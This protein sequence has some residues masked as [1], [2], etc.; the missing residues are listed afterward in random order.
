LRK[1]QHLHQYLTQAPTRLRKHQ[2]LHQY[3][4]QYLTQSPTRLRKHQ[5]LTQAPT[6][7]LTEEVLDILTLFGENG[8]LKPEK[9]A[10]NFF[11]DILKQ[12]LFHG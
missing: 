3:L 9:T 11:V 7:S 12:P 10:P 8:N 4:T 1:H 6:L 5:H 2:Y